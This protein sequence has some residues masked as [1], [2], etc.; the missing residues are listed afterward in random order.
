MPVLD[1]AGWTAMLEISVKWKMDTLRADAIAGLE[2]VLTEA[3]AARRVSLGRL[4]NV[5]R[6]ITTGASA[7]VQRA[8]PLNFSEIIW[9]GALSPAILA[10]REKAALLRAADGSPAAWADILQQVERAVGGAGAS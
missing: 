5:Q 8:E 6:W 9:L 7:L 1:V 2:R 3:D 10:L 4:F